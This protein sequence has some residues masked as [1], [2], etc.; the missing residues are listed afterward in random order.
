MKNMKETMAQDLQIL[1]STNLNELQQAVLNCL[2]R[3]LGEYESLNVFIES[4]LKSPSIFDSCMD[5]NQLYIF[6][7]E[8]NQLINHFMKICKQ[9]SIRFVFNEII[10]EFDYLL[11]WK[12][13][14]E[15]LNQLLLEDPCRKSIET[16][17]E[18]I[19][20]KQNLIQNILQNGMEKNKQYSYYPTEKQILEAGYD[21]IGYMAICS[22]YI[23]GYIS[24]IYNDYNK[25]ILIWNKNGDLD[26]RTQQI[27]FYAK[28]KKD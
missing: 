22:G 11:H 25:V 13:S 21:K 5:D 24:R 3:H 9:D 6:F 23:N 26:W 19:I 14:A 7:E 18:K 15:E 8:N 4:Y 20:E 2:M 10:K 12:K 1:K 16:L 27:V 28:E 17:K